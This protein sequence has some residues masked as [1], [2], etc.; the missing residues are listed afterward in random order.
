MRA[1]GTR[2]DGRDPTELEASR[3]STLDGVFTEYFTGHM[4]FGFGVVH[5]GFRTRAFGWQKQIKSH[6]LKAFEAV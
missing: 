4:V 5:I 2:P 3:A 1:V 6:D